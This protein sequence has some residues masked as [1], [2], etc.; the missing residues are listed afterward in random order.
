MVAPV[1]AREFVFFA[2]MFLGAIGAVALLSLRIGAVQRDHAEWSATGIRPAAGAW[3]INNNVQAKIV[4][5]DDETCDV[6][7]GEGQPYLIVCRRG[8]A[9][10]LHG[11]R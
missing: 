7:P 3:A 10:R 2:A 1:R 6:V 9:C 8:Q 11:A 5:H 4:C